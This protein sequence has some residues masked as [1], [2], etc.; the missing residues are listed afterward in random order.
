MKYHDEYNT[1]G[2]EGMSKSPHSSSSAV[3]RGSLNLQFA[4]TDIKKQTQ[5][6]AIHLL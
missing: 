3:F 4:N 6:S 5:E 1:M 2:R